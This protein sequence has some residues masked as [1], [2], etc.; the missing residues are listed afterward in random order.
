MP[1]ETKDVTRKNCEILESLKI[2]LSVGLKLRRS[3]CDK[4]GSFIDSSVRLKFEHF[5]FENEVN[6]GWQDKT[7]NLLKIE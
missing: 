3:I 4:S 7:V 2:D 1:G 6:S 5:L